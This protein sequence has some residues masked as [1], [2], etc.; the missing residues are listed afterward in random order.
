MEMKVGT[1]GEHY[2]KRSE[3]VKSEHRQEYFT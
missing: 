3:E 2:N 1:L